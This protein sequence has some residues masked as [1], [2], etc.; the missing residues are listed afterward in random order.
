[1]P[2]TKRAR[3]VSAARNPDPPGVWRQELQCAGCGTCKILR[4]AKAPLVTAVGMTGPKCTGVFMGRPRN[5][6]GWPMSYVWLFVPE[7]PL[8]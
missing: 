3:N 7:Q 2:A 4:V 8:A 5:R 1:M 6:C